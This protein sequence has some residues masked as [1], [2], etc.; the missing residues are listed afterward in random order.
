MKYPYLLDETL[1]MMIQSNL[2]YVISTDLTGHINYINQKTL[3]QFSEQPPL[4]KNQSFQDLLSFDDQLRFQRAM[5]KS[6][7]DI[8]LPVTVHLNGFIGATQPNSMQFSI[9]VIKDELYEAIGFL[10]IGQPAIQKAAE[11]SILQKYPISA[12]K[13]EFSAVANDIPLMIWILDNNLQCVYANNAVLKHFNSN[14]EHELGRG[15]LQKLPKQQ[16]TGEMGSFLHNLSTKKAF[17]VE[18]SLE[19]AAKEER[20]HFYLAPQLN[21]ECQFTGYIIYGTDI[22]H[23]HQVANAL[24]QQS[25]L[26]NV[27]NKEY[28]RFKKVANV[29]N[30]SILLTNTINQITWINAATTTMLGYELPEIAG[31]QDFKIFCGPDTDLEDIN[32]IK[33]GICN[34]TAFEKEMILYNKAGQKFKIDFIKEPIFDDQQVFT[35]FLIILSNRISFVNAN[36]VNL[37]NYAH[38]EIEE[39]VLIDDDKLVNEMNQLI[40]KSA[41]PYMPVKVF[42]DVDYALSH[43]NANPYTRRKIIL[44]LSFP[45]KSGWYFLD[46]YQK[47]DQPWSVVILTSS[48]EAADIERSKDY[49]FITHFI[50]KP[51]NKE[52]LNGLQ[53]LEARKLK[54]A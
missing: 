51:L 42:Y 40:I 27:L 32:N 10:F 22:T 7:E 52:Q 18:L 48:V 9:S 50:N 12:A 45:H 25:T 4:L 54:V 14:L 1:S 16:L 36:P 34:I 6:A 20:I 21:Q 37:N 33:S 41:F 23:V 31:Q 38:Q 11:S 29:S 28:I 15:Y 44:D 39:I 24:N 17:S 35:G 26:I 46:E 2:C 8:S 13:Q 53:I 43:I 19:N 5:K 3:D 47:L 49:R 30:Q